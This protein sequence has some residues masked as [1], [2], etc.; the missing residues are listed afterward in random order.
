MFGDEIFNNDFNNSFSRREQA[1]EIEEW[2][3][4]SYI[5]ECVINQSKNKINIT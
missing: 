5:N 4:I 1:S 3:V 2:H